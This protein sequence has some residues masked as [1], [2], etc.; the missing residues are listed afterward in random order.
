MDPVVL[1]ILV[2]HLPS[3]AGVL[4]FTYLSLALIVGGF[5]DSLWLLPIGIGIGI[6]VA[7]AART[8]VVGMPMEIEEHRRF[9]DGHPGSNPD[10]W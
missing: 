1:K 4:L 7:R 3:I 8:L 5:R 6:W 10:P 9:L 2:R